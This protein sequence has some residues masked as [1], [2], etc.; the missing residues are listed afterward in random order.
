ML[1]LL[2]VLM[3][4]GTLSPAAAVV[5]AISPSG[6]KIRWT[7]TGAIA[8]GDGSRTPMCLSSTESSGSPVVRIK[9]L[10]TSDHFLK[11]SRFFSFVSP[12]PAL[13][14]TCESNSQSPEYFAP[15]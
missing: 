15:G 8:M 6:L 7:P 5:E 14:E 10:G 2:A 9:R 11:A 12:V 13:P 1:V 3:M 4:Y